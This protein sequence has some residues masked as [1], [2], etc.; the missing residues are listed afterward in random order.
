MWTESPETRQ[1]KR[2]AIINLV[3]CATVKEE[4]NQFLHT[5]TPQFRKDGQ[6]SQNKTGL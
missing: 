2:V 3:I 4:N 5:F 6:C 1:K